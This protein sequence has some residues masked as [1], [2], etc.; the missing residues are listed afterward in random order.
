MPIF[1]NLSP[2]LRKAVETIINE[3]KSHEMCHSC[4]LSIKIDGRMRCGID[5]Y[6][7]NNYPGNWECENDEN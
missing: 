4:Q 7:R 6:G 5:T 3:C 2:D 1:K